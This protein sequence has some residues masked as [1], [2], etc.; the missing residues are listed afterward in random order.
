MGTSPRP[1]PPLSFPNPHPSLSGLFHRLPKAAD[2]SLWLLPGLQPK[3][4]ESRYLQEPSAHSAA[5]LVSHLPLDRPKV[6]GISFLLDTLPRASDPLP[7]GSLTATLECSIVVLFLEMRKLKFCGTF[8]KLFY[9]QAVTSETRIQNLS[10][11]GQ[12]TIYF[13]ATASSSVQ[14]PA[15]PW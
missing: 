4:I 6:G 9:M 1:K 13:S 10:V 5:S 3:R 12:T 7:N 2:G 11:P 15:G 8:A 14:L